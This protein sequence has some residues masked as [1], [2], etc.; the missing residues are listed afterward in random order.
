MQQIVWL[1]KSTHACCCNTFLLF[2]QVLVGLFRHDLRLWKA[3]SITLQV[4]LHKICLFSC[5]CLLTRVQTTCS[6]MM[7]S[8]STLIFLAP[9]RRSFR[10]FP[11]SR[12]RTDHC[13]DIEG[14]RFWSPTVQPGVNLTH[15]VRKREARGNLLQIAL[16]GGFFPPQSDILRLRQPLVQ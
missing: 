14:E 8:E 15:T 3:Y 6:R 11:I 5:V 10:P 1:C 7:C 9:W 13:R 2:P 12:C 16:F 4:S